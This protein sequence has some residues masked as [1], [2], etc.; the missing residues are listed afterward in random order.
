MRTSSSVFAGVSFGSVKPK[1]R[2]ESVGRVLEECHGRVGTRR[3]VIQRR[4]VEGK[5]IRRLVIIDAAIRG[6]AIVLH[7][8]REGAIAGTRCIHGRRENKKAG[9]NVRR[10]D[11]LAGRD[12]DPVQA[13]HT[14]SG[15]G[16]DAHAGKSVGWTVVRIAETEI[17]RRESIGGIFDDRDSVIRPLRGIV[18]WIDSNREGLVTRC[19]SAVGDAEHEAVGSGVR[20]VMHVADNTTI[21]L[22]LRKA[23]DRR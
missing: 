3:R 5:V 16:R 7:L 1:F 14:R 17:C 23:C 8:E 13:Q 19:K 20:A 9:R 18:G 22:G 12:S 11:G 4:H 15:Q 10:A 6:A 21:E 2:R